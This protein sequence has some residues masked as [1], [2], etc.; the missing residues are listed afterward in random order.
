MRGK[1]ENTCNCLSK[2][3][4]LNPENIFYNSKWIHRCNF[5]KTVSNPN[6]FII[7]GKYAIRLMMGKCFQNE[8]KNRDQK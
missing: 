4:T 8:D 7:K 5:R 2:I 1:D 3:K 6:K